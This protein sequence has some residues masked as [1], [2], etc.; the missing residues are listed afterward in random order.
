MGRYALGN[1]EII[2]RMTGCPNGCA[3][4]YLAEIGFVGTNPGLYNMHIGS[5]FQG[6]RL[7]KLYRENL[8]EEKIL[9]ELDSLFLRFS[10][11]RR[12]GEHFGDF[13]QR[14][15]LAS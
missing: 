9:R 1:E 14:K 7:N 11:E 12:L 6:T 13:A 4:P 10:A 2:I 15:I 8:D 5:D 3:R